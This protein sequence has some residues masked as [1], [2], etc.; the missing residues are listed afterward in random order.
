MLYTWLSFILPLV[1]LSICLLSIYPSIY[2]SRWPETKT[3]CHIKS[4]LIIK[5][6]TSSLKRP[7]QFFWCIHLC[8][9]I[10]P[11]IYLSIQL[12]IYLSIY[13]FFYR[14]IHLANNLSIYLSVHPFIYLLI[15]FYLSIYL[16]ACNRSA[17]QQYIMWLPLDILQNINTRKNRGVV[18]LRAGDIINMLHSCW[19]SNSLWPLVCASVG[20]SSVGMYILNWPLPKHTAIPPP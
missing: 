9:S 8:L 11:Y 2:K 13:K 16:S 17:C 1:Y 7:L 20:S 15:N 14:S 5:G 4:S 12:T 10:Y 19:K 18:M 3:H 6:A